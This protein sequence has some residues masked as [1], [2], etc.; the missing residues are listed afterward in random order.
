M[1]SFTRQGRSVARAHRVCIGASSSLVAAALVA[2]AGD[3]DAIASA[4]GACAL[5]GRDYGL[6]DGEVEH[7]CGHIGEGPY[8]ELAAGEQL[9][10][11]H[12][13]YTVAL[14][15][16]GDGRF[17][18]TL[19][20]VP[21]ATATHVF[22]AFDDATLSF[23]EGE[24]DALCIARTVEDVA[25]DPIDRALMVDLDEGRTIEVRIAPMD[26]PTVRI[27]AERR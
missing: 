7:A 2:C 22:Y 16:D 23:H 4:G 12:M 6:D 20:F 25:C 19:G 24:G 5:E 14:V 26:R 13:L 1:R 11:L 8:G 21:R 17:S 15:P 3:E 18:G 27:L 10:N 9:G